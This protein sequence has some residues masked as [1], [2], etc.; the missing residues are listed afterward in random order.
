MISIYIVYDINLWS[1]IQGAEFAFGNSLFGGVKFIEN[2]DPDKYKYNRY[3]IGFDV[4]GSFLLSNGS[5][6]GK[7]VITFAADELICTY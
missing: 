3:G 1:S 6:F 2:S 7:N 4:Y 5:G